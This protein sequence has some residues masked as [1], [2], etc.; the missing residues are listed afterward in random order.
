M[1]HKNNTTLKNCKFETLAWQ[2]KQYVCGIDEVGRGALSGPLIV[3]A[4]I[5]PIGTKYNFL[6]DSKLLTAKTRGVAYQWLQQ[7]ATFAIAAVP[8]RTIDSINIYQ[9]TLL[10]MRKA[11][12]GLQA[13]M[14]KHQTLKYVI[15]DAMPFDQKLTLAE[16]QTFP[17][18]ESRSISVAAAS[19]IAKE[20][21]D[22]LMATMERYFPAYKSSSHKG[23]GTAVHTKELIKNGQESLIHRVTFVKTLLKNKKAKDKNNAQQKLF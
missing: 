12:L 6:K 5:L 9:A 20:E 3:C 14:Q 8:P 1:N 21:R 17:K 23:Y 11:F 10:A 13:Q 18:A 7:H 22:K 16:I 19:I 4:A 15:T 2:Q